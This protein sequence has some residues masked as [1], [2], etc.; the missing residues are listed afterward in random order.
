M[1][2]TD[3]PKSR[4]MNCCSPQHVLHG[5]QLYT[6]IATL[7]MVKDKL[8]QEPFQGRKLKQHV[9]LQKCQVNMHISQKF[10]LFIL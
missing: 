4:S 8:I 5:Q 3:C 9:K 1:T 6:E 2:E 10:M 7:A